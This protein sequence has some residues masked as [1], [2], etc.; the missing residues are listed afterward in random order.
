MSKKVF[1]QIAE[2]LNEAL[3]VARGEAEPYKLHVPAEGAWLIAG[4]YHLGAHQNQCD[5][6]CN[7]MV[8]PHSALPFATNDSGY[9]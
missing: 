8:N 3:A 4:L 5:S 7:D 2:G 1:D 9:S 6:R